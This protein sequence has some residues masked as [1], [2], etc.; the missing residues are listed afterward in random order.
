[1]DSTPDIEQ[2]KSEIDEL[3]E[4]VNRL[5]TE[6]WKGRLQKGVIGDL[7]LLTPDSWFLRSKVSEMISKQV[8]IQWVSHHQC[9]TGNNY[10]DDIIKKCQPEPSDKVDKVIDL[11]RDVADKIGCQDPRFAC[12]LVGTGSY[13]D[14]TK[15]TSFNE[16]DFVL[17]MGY[18]CHREYK[19]MLTDI[20]SESIYCDLVPSGDSLLYHYCS[21]DGVTLD[22]KRFRTDFNKV[23]TEALK[24][25]CRVKHVDFGGFLRPC[26][27]GFTVNGPALTVKLDDISVDLTVTFRV[28]SHMTW[29]VLKHRCRPDLLRLTKQSIINYAKRGLAVVSPN[30]FTISLSTS[31]IERDLFHHNRILKETLIVAK[32]YRD[33]W[34]TV[35][36]P[37]VVQCFRELID[38]LRKQIYEVFLRC[39][40]LGGFWKRFFLWP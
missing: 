1:M 29:R 21:D 8:S 20:R 7:D 28:P 32:Y 33:H 40:N 4:E 14:G 30:S 36:Y 16:M 6:E 37:S 10:C 27:G 35:Y 17:L 31:L 3:T 13:H 18:N 23:L 22:V 34:L 26:Y 5:L 24:E 19:L 11:V 15:I 9:L 39:H 2:L 38:N 25:S 12:Q